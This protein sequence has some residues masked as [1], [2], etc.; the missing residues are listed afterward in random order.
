MCY[1]NH[2]L[3]VILHAAINV[4]FMLNKSH[5]ILMHS[6]FLNN[7]IVAVYKLLLQMID[8]IPKPQTPGADTSYVKRP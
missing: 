1:Q 8:E 7:L 5:K 2:K 3:L 4:D 6:N